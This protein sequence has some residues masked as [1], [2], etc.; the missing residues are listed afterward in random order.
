VLFSHISSEFLVNF[1]MFSNFLAIL[2]VEPANLG[3]NRESMG[4]KSNCSKCGR[5]VIPLQE[6]KSFYPHH[7]PPKFGRFIF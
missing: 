3:I 6:F 5:E 1:R 4:D 7:K 2:G